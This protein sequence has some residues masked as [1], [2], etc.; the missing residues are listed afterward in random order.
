MS[1]LRNALFTRKAIFRLGLKQGLKWWQILNGQTV[2]LQPRGYAGSMTIRGSDSDRHVFWEIFVEKSIHIP[3]TSEPVDVIL[4]LGGNTG[5]AA[6]YYAHHFPNTRVISVE[7]G[8]ENFALLSQNTRPW[9]NITPVQKGVWWRE[10]TLRVINPQAQS[11]GFRFEET[12]DEGV[13]CVTVDQLIDTYCPPG[14]RVMVK[15]DIEGAEKEI[16]NNGPSW[17][18]R[19][20]CLQIEI[21]NCWK[22]VFDALACYDYEASILADTVIFKFPRQP[23]ASH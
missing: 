5:L 11:W 18:G 21:H 1:P 12:E 23:T 20:D 13:Q 17:I 19:I 3:K 7:P 22:N 2:S 6:I 16:F 15:M 4:D 14:S 10:A 9:K 8:A